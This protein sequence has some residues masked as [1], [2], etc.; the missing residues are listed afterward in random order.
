MTKQPT[1]VKPYDVVI[2]RPKLEGNLWG[3]WRVTA[4]I[5][6]KGLFQPRFAEY[7][8]TAHDRAE[9]EKK[10]EKLADRAKGASIYITSRNGNVH[11]LV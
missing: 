3:L 1:L 8:D 9:A 7:I 4:K 6:I 5:G 11:P 2:E 10:A